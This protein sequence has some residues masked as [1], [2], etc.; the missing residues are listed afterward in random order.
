M[1]RYEIPEINVSVFDTE[2]VL[3]ASSIQQADTVTYSDESASLYMAEA[4]GGT[5]EVTI[6]NPF[7]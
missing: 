4:N 3:T 6:T 1:K 2:D 5:S 7:N